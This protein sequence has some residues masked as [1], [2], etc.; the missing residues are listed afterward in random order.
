M[1]LQSVVHGTR[2]D[3]VWYT[4]AD[5]PASSGCTAC[6]TAHSRSCTRN[7]H[8]TTTCDSLKVNKQYLHHSYIVYPDAARR[9]AR[10]RDSSD[11]GY[12]DTN[13]RIVRGLW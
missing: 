12:F 6:W 5:P 4:V 11:V 3:C 2:G 1:C 13:Q 10:L 7:Q 9:S 8:V